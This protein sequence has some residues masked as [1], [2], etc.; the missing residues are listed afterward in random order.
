MQGDPVSLLLFVLAVDL[1]QSL[2]NRIKDM[3][4][5]KLPI[6]LNNNRDF[7]IL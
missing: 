2:V 6:H 7:P 5:L 1:L 3:S 4:L